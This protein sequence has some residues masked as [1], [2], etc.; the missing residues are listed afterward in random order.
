LVGSSCGVHRFKLHP[1]SRPRPL[2]SRPLIRSQASRSRRR[3]KSTL[4]VGRNHGGP[5]LVA[6]RVVEGQPRVILEREN[7]RFATSGERE[8]DRGARDR[9]HF[10]GR[11]KRERGGSARG[12]RK[13]GRSRRCGMLSTSRKNSIPWQWRRRHFAV[14]ATLGC[15]RWDQIS[16]G[17]WIRQRGAF[18]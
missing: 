12:E 3:P 17:P 10:G 4:R 16:P 7:A 11:I 13:E 5:S 14:P 1:R 8:G 18:S 6:L 2:T 9:S 15:R